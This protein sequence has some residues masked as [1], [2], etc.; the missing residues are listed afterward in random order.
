MR[1]CWPGMAVLAGAVLLHAQIPAQTI[2]EFRLPAK[3]VFP[4]AMPRYPNV[5]FY[6]DAKLAPSY[7][8]A[9]KLVTERVS[10]TMRAPEY[11]P[12]FDNPEG[13]DH[14]IR[15]EHL[16]SWIDAA[17]PTLKHAHAF[18][19]RYYYSALAGP[20]LQRIR[21]GGPGAARD[22]Y[23]FAASAHYEVEHANPNHADVEICPICGRTGEYAA[24]KGNLVER[25]H[26]PLGLELALSGEIRGQLVRFEDFEGRAVGSLKN[27]ND[28]FRISTL[29]FPAQGKDQ[30]TLRIGIVLIEPKP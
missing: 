4:A 29:I 17:H 21:V 2:D 20:E 13:C 11:Y 1:A 19:M 5:W 10:A 15:I 18:H 16:Q 22:F 28:Q 7:K 9:V 23:R 24:E 27:M 26:D 3:S 25:V 6:I 14:E 30:N 8:A 12:P